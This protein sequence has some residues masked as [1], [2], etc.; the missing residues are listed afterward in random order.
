MRRS[1]QTGEETFLT[2]CAELLGD[3]FVD[4]NS[5]RRHADL[6]L[7]QERPKASRVDGFA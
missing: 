6:S 5:L 2:I 3:D 4:E 1:P 7:V